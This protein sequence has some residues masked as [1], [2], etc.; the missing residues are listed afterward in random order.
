MSREQQKTSIDYD[1]LMRENLSRVFN[2]RD[3]TVR[4]QAIQEIYADD[5][6]LYEPPDTLARG[7]GAIN[8][9]VDALWLNLPPAFIFTPTGP[10]AGH[11]GVGKLHW[12]AGPPDG[13]VAIT[14]A[15]VAHFVD[16]RIHSLYVFLDQPGA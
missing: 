6:T 14:G 15:D 4:L 13:P 1:R 9:A 5:A 16:G 2:E 7:H 3:A 10:A 8:Q 11:H 12:Q